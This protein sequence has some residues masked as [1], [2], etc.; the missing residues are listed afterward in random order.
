MLEE[1]R[2]YIGATVKNKLE[3]RL[4]EHF[5]STKCD[6]TS[7]YKPIAIRDIIVIEKGL[8]N[9]ENIITLRYMQKYGIDYVRGG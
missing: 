3:D 5:N 4:A 2:W 9:Q 7:L 6:W 1:G 8:T